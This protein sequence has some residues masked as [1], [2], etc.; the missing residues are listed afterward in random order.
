[1]ATSRRI[2]MSVKAISVLLLAGLAAPGLSQSFG[3]EDDVGIEIA[4]EQRI[5]F[6]A[7]GHVDGYSEAQT[8]GPRG[9]K[10]S[11]LTLETAVTAA[12]PIDEQNSM[13][14]SLG[15]ASTGYD[16]NDFRAFGTSAP[17]DLID[18]GLSVSLSATAMHH[19]DKE[20]SLFGGASVRS[21]GEIG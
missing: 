18:Y 4:P 21:E 16:F 8:R 6:F 14:V 3:D 10:L 15:Q 19:I 17:I 9:G 5:S 11:S 12:I 2:Q 7:R 13:T 1:Q 20:W